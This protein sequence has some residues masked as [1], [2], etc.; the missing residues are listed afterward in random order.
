[1]QYNHKENK[2]FQKSAAKKK[3]IGTKKIAIQGNN[4]RQHKIMQHKYAIQARNNATQPKTN[5]MQAR[6]NA[7]Q[8]KIMLYFSI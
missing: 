7:K 3:N 2:T 4:A 6:N 5:A 8:L 1:M